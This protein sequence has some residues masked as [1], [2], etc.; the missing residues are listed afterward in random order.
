MSGLP[1]ISVKLDE[2][3]IYGEIAIDGQKLKGVR[4]FKIENT[5]GSPCRIE[6]QLIG[7]VEFEGPG[8]LIIDRQME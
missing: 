7:T 5:V 3:G 4:G 2:M 1:T 8:V 6:V